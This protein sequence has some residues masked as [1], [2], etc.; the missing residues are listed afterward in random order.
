[1]T[2]DSNRTAPAGQKPPRFGIRSLLFT[3]VL[4]LIFFLLF[5]SMARHRFHEGD[6][7]N[8]NGTL[9]P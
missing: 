8:R 2:T 5:Q 1:M 6:R 7:L 3:V 9:R 4:A